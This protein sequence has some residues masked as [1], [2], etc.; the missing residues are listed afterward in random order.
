MKAVEL[1]YGKRKLSFELPWSWEAEVLRPNPISP[2]EDPVQEIRK[3]LENPLGAKKLENF[4]GAASVAVAISD[5][6]R[7]VP[8]RLILP[9]L[10]EKLT[11]MGI[12]KSETTILIASGLHAPL[13][14]S[15]FPNLLS[16]E[17]LQQYRLLVHDAKAPDLQAL[18]TTARG[19]P[20]F[21]HPS[22][23]RA[24]LRIVVGLIDPHQFVGYTGGVKC[25]AVG[26]AGAQ[27]IE[28]NHSLLFHPQ[29]AVG[30]IHTNPVRQDIEEIGKLMG[31]HFVVNVVLDETN[32][33][34]KA[35]SGD[36]I[37]VEKVGSEFC[38]TVCEVQVSGEYD[39][40]I[41]SPGGYPK[42]INVYQTQK[43]LAHATPL[44]RKGGDIILFAECPDGHGSETFYETMKKCHHP[45]EVIDRFKKEKFKMGA[46]KAF[47]WARFLAKAQVH[48]FSTLE[49]R[50]SRELMTFP[51]K[52]V[53]E[54]LSRL[55][56]KYPYPPRI[57]VLPKANST[58]AKIR[59]R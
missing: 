26:L 58:Y 49:E 27:T 4:Q 55:K 17:I 22:F 23:H 54:V 35:F 2:A 8:N 40:V 51:S 16:P 1:P 41:A 44:V 48:L 59:S 20:V 30:E 25:A 50:L 3:S 42:D 6:T 7:P 46:H 56:S 57:A 32:R 47:L 15:R 21:V 24:D 13:P 37:E 9:I 52:E 31:V 39:V 19:T 43:G 34:V 53:M 38:H 12:P 36:P 33:L 10:L 28:A 45:Q 14:S 5:E 11:K 18:G 29:A